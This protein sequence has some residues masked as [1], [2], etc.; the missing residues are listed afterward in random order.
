M[1]CSCGAT[2]RKSLRSAPAGS[3]SSCR[4]GSAAVSPPPARFRAQC[5][6]LEEWSRPL[7]A[8]PDAQ[9]QI[10][11]RLEPEAV[12]LFDDDAFVPVFGLPYIAMSA[13]QLKPFFY[14]LARDCPQKLGMR[15]LNHPL[16]YS[17]FSGPEGSFGYAAVTAALM[18]R[19][20]AKATVGEAEQRL[21]ALPATDAGLAELGKLEHDTPSSLA[22]LTEKERQAFAVTLAD[23][24]TRIAR[25]ILETRISAIG[26]LPATRR[27]FD[28]LDRLQRRHQRVAAARGRKDQRHVHRPRP[29]ACD[30]GGARRRSRPARRRR[31]CIAARLGRDGKGQS[32]R[33][34]LWSNALASTADRRLSPTPAQLSRGAPLF[35]PT[36]GC[37]APSA[38][39]CLAS[40]T[41]ALPPPSWSS[42]RRALL[43]PN[44]I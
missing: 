24:R 23:N 30:R 38:T 43:Q 39:P 7:T 20:A 22:L 4:P 44:E 16:L 8:R 19:R 27:E 37:S 25:G 41:P 34:T 18:N 11:D 36:P 9:T 2:R 29:G 12:P 15:D 14:L 31:S 35:S 32:R 3:A 17:P 21:P 40:R 5:D 28:Q 33:L 6:A 13:A 10:I 26:D 42:P 1:R